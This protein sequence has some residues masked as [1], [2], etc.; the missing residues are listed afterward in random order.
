[1][2]IW[3]IVNVKNKTPGKRYAHNL[4]YKKPYLVVI[5][6][7]LENNVTND[8]W[9]LDIQNK[10]LIW[11]QIKFAGEAPQPRDYHSASLCTF[12][13][14]SGMIVLFGGRSAKREPI[15]D[16]WGLVKHV[17]SGEW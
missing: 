16:C 5:G 15:N 11:S 6:G 2:G 12:G 1:M 14:A 4:V 7:N 17:S 13:S 10:P 3:N 8:V 9:V